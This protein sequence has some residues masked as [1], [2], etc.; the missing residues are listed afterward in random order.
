MSHFD[1]RRFNAIPD[2]SLKIF[3][4]ALTT[5]DSFLSYFDLIIYPPA[6]LPCSQNWEEASREWQ[7]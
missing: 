6:I 1:L 3:F 7:F 2:L 4:Y 5:S